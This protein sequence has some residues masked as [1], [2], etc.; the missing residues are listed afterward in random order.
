MR[1]R[2]APWPAAKVLL[3]TFNPLRPSQYDRH[4]VSFEMR[5]DSASD[6]VTMLPGQVSPASGAL[7]QGSCKVGGVLPL[8][9]R[10]VFSQTLNPCNRQ[11]T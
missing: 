11:W 4:Q 8:H 9:A 10:L 5:L 6:Y 2:L 1:P 3:E 7:A